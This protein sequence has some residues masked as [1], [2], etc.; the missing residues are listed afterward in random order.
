MPSGTPVC[1]R[2]TL[3][4]CLLALFVP[5]KWALSRALALSVRIYLLGEA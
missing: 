4:L 2:D 3:E 5:L 1:W